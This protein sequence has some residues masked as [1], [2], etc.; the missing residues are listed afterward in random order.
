MSN[1]SGGIRPSIVGC[2]ALISMMALLIEHSEEWS[3]DEEKQDL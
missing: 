2:W 3:R 1:R